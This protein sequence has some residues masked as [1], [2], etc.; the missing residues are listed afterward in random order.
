MKQIAAIYLLI[1]VLAA[2][3]CTSET[4]TQPTST[5]TNETADRNSATIVSTATP[6]PTPIPTQEPPQPTESSP[7]PTNTPESRPNST[8][9]PEAATG[10]PPAPTATTSPSPT[11]R[12]APGSTSTP[13]SRP[14][15]VEPPAD[16]ST[17]L[18]ERV[19]SINATV[20]GLR[21][22]ETPVSDTPVDDRVYKSS[23]DKDTT[24]Y[25]SWEFTLAYP[26]HRTEAT[27]LFETAVR[28]AA[29]RVIDLYSSSPTVEADWTG[30]Y[31]QARRGQPAAGSWEP[32]WYSVT[33]SIDDGEVATGWF[34]VTDAADAIL[35]QLEQRLDGTVPWLTGATETGE[36]RA[37]SALLRVWQEDPQL[38][39]TMAGW[40]WVANGMSSKEPEVLDQLATLAGLSSVAA[41][42]VFS[43][44][45]VEDGVGDTEWQALR[46]LAALG[47]NDL[48]SLP[49]VAQYAWLAD[50]ITGNES[51]S[52][53]YLA[54]LARGE[55]NVTPA[56]ATDWP[57]VRD[58][59]TEVERWALQALSRLAESDRALGHTVQALP[60][61]ADDML[62]D[63]RWGLRGL[64]VLVDWDFD[65]AAL[66]ADY[67][68]V[69]DGT[70]EKEWRLIDALGDL[71][72]SHAGLGAD[73]ARYAWVAD[74]ISDDERWAM[75]TLAVI[76]VRDTAFAQEIAGM[77]FMD[78]PFRARDRYALASI[79]ELMD[80]PEDLA[81]LTGRPWFA[82]GLNDEDAAFVAMLADIN[83]RAPNQFRDLL[84]SHYVRSATVHLPIAG[85]V[86]LTAF[87]R[88]PFQRF[89]DILDLV[90][91]SL[92]AT[93]QFMGVGFPQKDVLLLFVDPLYEWP[94]IN[95]ASIAFNIGGRHMLVTRQEV[96]EGDYRNAVAHEVS[97]YYWHSNAPL[98]LTEGGADF[99]AS[100][101]LDW[102]GH[103]PLSDRRTVLGSNDVN[104]VCK[105]RGVENLQRL[106]TLLSEQGLAA[107]ADSPQF[108]CNYAVGE[109]FLI[110][111]YEALGPEGASQAWQE[112]YVLAQKEERPATETEIYLAFLRNTPSENV[113]EF[114]S[115]YSRWHG[116]QIPNGEAE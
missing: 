17:V 48:Q 30:S 40:S 112:L 51:S 15:S 100:F 98:W 46:N 3:A 18:V 6:V 61:V 85:E 44:P 24:R 108:F 77:N 74:G 35:A 55:P 106:I 89:D 12:P 70:T 63:E 68:W 83:A 115:V 5:P 94:A 52:L 65:L 73:A 57:W 90:E 58:E 20:V 45:W 95:D 60:W 56:A 81:N 33:I 19:P 21:F 64:S 50:D 88:T 69:A 49:I 22:F 92:Q 71:E 41:E 4:Q 29:G 8:L 76:A 42:A 11:P 101:T 16:T 32:G 34:E 116:G 36:T 10:T 97:H 13:P 31:H 113:A 66:V 82:D 110:N 26:A 86:D 109:Y 28:D 25:V 80:L 43:W 75:A 54:V 39:E 67:P 99:L 96:I 7:Q 102:N 111:V 59:I 105:G 47:Q 14:T 23:F 27:F 2:V 79:W 87:R 53:E 62:E 72:E 104:R 38:A 37:R 107:H 103:R 1:I 93:E 114:N 91:D 78:A 9:V 84:D